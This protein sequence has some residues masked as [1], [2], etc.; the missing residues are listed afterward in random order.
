MWESVA[1]IP[2]RK[3]KSSVPG[4]SQ[5]EVSTIKKQRVF[6][7]SKSIHK[8][9]EGKTFCKYSINVYWLLY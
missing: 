2:A 1:V 5:A 3:M 7:Y 8:L 4:M 9:S 6:S